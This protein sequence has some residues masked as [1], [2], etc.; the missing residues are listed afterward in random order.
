MDKNFFSTTSHAKFILILL[1]VSY[2]VLM[3]G[4]GIITLTHPDEVFYVQTAKEMIANRSWLTPMIFGAPQFEKPVLFYWLLILCIKVFG[5]TSFVARLSPALFAIIGVGITYWL[6]WLFFQSKRIS[7][8]SGLV[9]CSSFIY[10]ALSRAVLTD[11]V[12]TVWILI[13]ITF[14]AFAYQNRKYKDIGI[15]L[16][17]VFSAIA[18]LTKGLLGLCFP[19]LI[20]FL[21]LF[22]KKELNFFKNKATLFGL[23]L[24]GLIAIP[25]HVI[26]YQLHGQTFVNDYWRNVHIRRL[27]IPEHHKNNTW[28]FYLAVMF[29]GM[30]P[31]SF[32]T[33]PSLRL[34]YK[35]TKEAHKDSDGLAFLLLSVLGTYVLV[36]PAQ[37]KLASYIFPVYPAIA[38]FVSYYLVT[39]MDKVAPKR[40]LS[41]LTIAGFMM[42]IMMFVGS[43]LSIVNAKK[44][45]SVVTNMTPVYVFSVLAFICA[46][47]LLISNIKKKYWVMIVANMGIT[48]MI[49]VVLFLGKDMAEP[50]VSCAQICERFKTV[51]QSDSVV[52]SSKF[53]VRGVR[54]FTDRKI[55]YMDI[56]GKGFYTPHPIPA[57]KT[58]EKLLQFL[59]KQPVT[60]GIVRK[61][62]IGTLDWTTKNKYTIH[63]LGMAIGG[64]H[65]V[66]I[67]KT[68]R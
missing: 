9:L 14:F 8:L 64:K 11:M 18:V 59:D 25:W 55:A 67:I 26:M 38:I 29:G 44:H 45:I 16:S 6:S 34:V 20:I 56:R 28:Y 46:C 19:A 57:L 43:V 65:I 32:F 50:W 60:Y 37:A 1:A 23:L 4:N 27:F 21:F 35:R 12:F 53:Y 30:M 10:F 13:S 61:A 40:W 58:P 24:F 68:K 41:G 5:M 47:T 36:Q 52:L 62:D 63:D 39:A 15:I 66:R 33:I 49:L 42:S 2:V 7:F 3:L 22:Y 54:F 48:V 31:W 17:F 51:D